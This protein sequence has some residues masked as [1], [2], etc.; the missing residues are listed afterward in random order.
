[1]LQNFEIIAGIYEEFLLGYKIVKSVEDN[2]VS[3]CP[4]L[5]RIGVDFGDKTIY[6]HVFCKAS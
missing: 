6:Y 2:K 4:L 5:L 1:M 3:F